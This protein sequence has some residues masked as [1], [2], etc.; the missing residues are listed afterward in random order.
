MSKYILSD[1]NIKTA[2][3]YPFLAQGKDLNLYLLQ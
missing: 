1:G 3:F 2:L